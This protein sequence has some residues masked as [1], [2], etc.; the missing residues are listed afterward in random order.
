[1]KTIKFAVLVFA[2]LWGSVALAQGRIAVFDLEAAVLNTDVAKQRLNALRNQKEFKNNVSELEQV[3]KDYEKLVEQ[4]QKDLEILSAEQR[5]LA[6]NKIDT[7]RSD[8][9]HL[10]RKIEAAQQQEVQ[11]IMAEIGP[12]LQK[13]LPEIIK[14]ENIGL[15]LPA[16]AVMH[17]DAGYNITAKVADKLNQAK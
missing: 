6:K 15:L 4:F 1:M 14:E 2:M 9:E 16:K 3:R 11:T 17:A 7:K 10:A 8:G 5:Q 12:K 13:L